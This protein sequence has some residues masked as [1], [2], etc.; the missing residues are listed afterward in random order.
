MIHNCGLAESLM[1]WDLNFF[2]V[3]EPQSYIVKMLESYN[4]V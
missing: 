4:L 2:D 1:D 3:F